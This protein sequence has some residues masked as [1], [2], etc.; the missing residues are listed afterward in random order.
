MFSFICFLGQC[1]Q[2]REVV[3]SVAYHCYPNV[4]QDVAWSCR[5]K[6]MHSSQRQLFHIWFMCLNLLNWVF[7]F[8][9]WSSSVGWLFDQQWCIVHWSH[10]ASIQDHLVCQFVRLRFRLN[11]WLRSE[12]IW[13]IPRGRTPLSLSCVN[14]NWKWENG[15]KSWRKLQER[16]IH[17]GQLG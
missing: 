12:A 3:T 13:G 11:G 4:K 15:L 5:V 17:Q 1:D 16:L 8:I 10:F 7:L 14:T 2:K 6:E 9:L